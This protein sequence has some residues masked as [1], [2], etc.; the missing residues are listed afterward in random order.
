[1]PPEIA[2]DYDRLADMI[3][4]RLSA[5]PP[6]RWLDTP[7]AAAHLGVS[8]ST[9]ERWRSQGRSGSP[10]YSVIGDAAVRYDIHALDK[11]AESKAVKS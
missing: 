2:L 11:W 1:M 5:A 7:A 8:K 9:L 4:A 3:A 10:P 6:T